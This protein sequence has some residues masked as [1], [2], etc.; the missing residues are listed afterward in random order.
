MRA[1]AADTSTAVM[2]VRS[3]LI[4]LMIAATA[5]EHGLTLATNNAADYRDIPGLLIETP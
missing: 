4:D 1:D 2:R 3:R 5:L